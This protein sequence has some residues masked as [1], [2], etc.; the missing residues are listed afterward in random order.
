METNA[1]L[2]KVISLQWWQ[3][4]GFVWRRTGRRMWPTSSN[5]CRGRRE[6]RSLDS[7]E[8]FED[9]PFGSQVSIHLLTFLC[10]CV[11]LSLHLTL[12]LHYYNFWHSQV[13]GFAMNFENF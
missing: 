8:D 10:V 11:Y 2:M 9:A 3:I 1:W 4:C 7:E 6:D 13:K 5:T 12:H